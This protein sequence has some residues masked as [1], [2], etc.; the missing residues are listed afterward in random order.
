MNLKSRLEY[1]QSKATDAE[2]YTLGVFNYK[3]YVSASSRLLP[4]IQ[5]QSKNLAF[6]PFLQIV[7]RKHGDATDETHE[8]FGGPLVDDLSHSVKMSLTPGPHLDELNLKMGARAVAEIDVLLDDAGRGQPIWLNAWA[9]HAVVQASSC[10]VYGEDHPFL[11]PEVEKA[12]WKWQT[13]LTA[14]LAGPWMDM[15]GTGYALREK[16]FK[17]YIKYSKVLPDHGSH[18]AKEHHR[19]LK[20]AGVT[21]TDNAKQAAIFTIAAFSNSAPTL[22]WTLWELFSRPEVLSEVR[23]ELEVHAIGGSKERGFVL[24]VAAVKSSCPLLLSVFQETQRI[25]HVNPSFRKV[26]ADTWLDNKYLL[27]AGEFLQIPGNPIHTEEGIWGQAASEFDPYRFVPKKGLERDGLPTSG[28]MA[29]G[30]PP[31]LCPARQFASTEILIVAA[32]MAIRADLRPLTG[33]WDKKP[34]L[35]LADLST[36]SNPKK[37]VQMD[38]G[39]RGQ[40]AGDWTLKMGESKSRISLASG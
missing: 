24:D 4:L 3:I 27:K 2:I 23:Q 20:D 38:V 1:G 34:A 6:R 5:K 39:A 14:H 13:Y 18:L 12:F 21:E 19:T 10:G 7:A 40:W 15:F 22:Y 17:A 32:L 33:V 11:D 26:M 37:D 30:A 16:V 36:L 28:F 29:W 35:N 9:R 8:I 25:R 31:Y